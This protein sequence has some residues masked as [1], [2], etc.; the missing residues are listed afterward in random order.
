MSVIRMR[1]L[2]WDR[3]RR[4]LV[5]GGPER[6]AF[7]FATWSFS[8][9]EPVFLVHDVELVPEEQVSHDR[10]GYDVDPEL[11]IAYVNRAVRNGDAIIEAHSHGGAL[12]RFSSHVDRPGLAETSSYV[13]SS[14]P[15]R[16]YAALVWGDDRVYGE[17][18]M[19]DGSKGTIRSVTVVGQ[20]L[21]QLVSRENDLDPPPTRFD[22]QR[23]W[24]LPAVQQELGRMR[25]AVLGEGGTGSHV[26]QQLVYL[27][28][29]EFV[30]IDPDAAEATNMNRLVTATASDVGTDKAILARRLVRSVAPDAQ[31]QVITDSF[32]APAAIDAVRGCDVVFACFDDDGPR[33]VA[34]ELAL[35]YDLPLFDIGVGIEPDDQGIIAEAG[36]R[37]AIFLPGGACLQC[38]GLIDHAEAGRYLKP[39]DQRQTDRERG[40]VRDI[41]APAVVSLNGALASIAVSEFAMAL[42]GLRAVHPYLEFDLLGAGRTI[43][44]QWLTPVRVH[45][46]SGCVLCA[47]ARRGD[48]ADIERHDRGRNRRPDSRTNNRRPLR[49]GLS[50]SR[51]GP[52][53]NEL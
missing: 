48:A 40:Y 8:S 31:V 36:G 33:L 41:T 23:P 12:P 52:E 43:P 44:T 2:V 9:G 37:V 19:A 18:W 14:L 34:T 5:H 7:F 17:H 4:H 20:R 50:T 53:V 45:R 11:L 42:S 22:R 38:M 32:L 6:F 24:F 13:L 25:V 30:L 29:R 10:L 51:R 49:L 1:E 21:R 39:P 28:V 3:V 27:G 16:P 35:A 15:G 26:V 47:V 46:E